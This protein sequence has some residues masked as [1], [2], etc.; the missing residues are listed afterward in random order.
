MLREV[1]RPRALT[2][3]GSQKRNRDGWEL[4]PR[5]PRGENRAGE[6]KRGK[7]EGVASV[8][9]V[10]SLHRCRWVAEN[11]VHPGGQHCRGVEARVPNEGWVCVPSEEQAQDSLHH[12]GVQRTPGGEH[13][14]EVADERGEEGAVEALAEDASL[15]RKEGG[16]HACPEDP[17]LLLQR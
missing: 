1:C 8:A 10:A 5:R 16:D 11:A 6:A 4:G 17:P 2:G 3:A 13:I 9:S 15:V 14:D 12:A 7:R